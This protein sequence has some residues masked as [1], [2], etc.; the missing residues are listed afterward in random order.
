MAGRPSLYTAARLKTIL[1]CVRRGLPL[2]LAAQAAGV[3]YATLASWRDRNPRFGEALSR[4]IARGADARLR[5]IEKASD[6]GD[7]RASAWLLEHTLPQHFARNRVEVTGAD[8]APLAGGPTIVLAWP[9]QQQ[10]TKIENERTTIELTESDPPSTAPGT[11]P[12]P[13]PQCPF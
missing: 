7:W 10:S 1:G 13:D 9:H 2:S 6:A 4:A 12:S 8:G 5:K 11:N 3:T